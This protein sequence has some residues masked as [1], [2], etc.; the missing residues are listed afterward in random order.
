MSSRTGRPTD[1]PKNVALH[2]RLDKE[3]EEILNA[4]CKQE[5]VSKMEG[6][7]RG[8]KMLRSELKK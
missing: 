7:R 4:Y 3:S 6:A 8:I 5:N 2:V 1:N